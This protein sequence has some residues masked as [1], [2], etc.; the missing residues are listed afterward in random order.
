MIRPNEA[1]QTADA[2]TAYRERSSVNIARADST[3][4]DGTIASFTRGNTLVVPHTSSSL[5]RSSSL[6]SFRVDIRR[7]P[8]DR[9]LIGLIPT[10]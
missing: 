6:G 10:A 2:T 5:R 3:A 7:R 9:L 8:R 1:M 4:Q